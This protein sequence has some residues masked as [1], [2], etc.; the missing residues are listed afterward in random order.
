[1]NFRFFSFPSVRA[2][3]LS[4]PVRVSSFYFLLFSLSF[5]SSCRAVC[6]SRLDV[7]ILTNPQNYASPFF[8]LF[9]KSFVSS[10]TLY[11]GTLDRVKSCSS[12]F[13]SRTP[14]NNTSKNTSQINFGF[15]N[16]RTRAFEH[17]ALATVFVQNAIQYRAI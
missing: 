9:E 7:C 8:V 1:M 3:I 6:V 17:P 12:S 5:P 11:R 15:T 10:F 2:L 4:V 13:I 14:A 16:Q